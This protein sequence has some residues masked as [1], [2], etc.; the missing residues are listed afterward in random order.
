MLRSF[1]RA[2]KALVALS[3]RS[4]SFESSNSHWEWLGVVLSSSGLLLAE[5]S[6]SSSSRSESFESSSSRR[7]ECFGVALSSSEWLEVARNSSE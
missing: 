4:E 6:Q 5:L 2:L 3:S 1:F 7:S